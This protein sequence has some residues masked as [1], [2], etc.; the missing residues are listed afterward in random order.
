[1]TLRGLCVTFLE[2]L[3]LV[4]AL[5]TE[6]REFFVVA[7]CVGGVIVYSLFSL[8]LASVTLRAESRLNTKTA[9]RGDEV[10]Y[11]LRLRG[12]A[13]LPVTGYL[14]VKSTEVFNKELRRRKH[15]FVML[16]SFKASHDFDFEMPCLHVGLWEVGIRKLRFEDV[17]GLFSLPL[18]RTRRYDY[19]IDLTIMPKIHP[20]ERETENSSSGDY[21]STSVLDAEEGELLGDSRIYRE[22][23]T[24]KRINWKMSARTK[25][26]YSRQYEMPQKP[27]IV[28]VTDSAISSVSINDVTDISG[29]V[30]VSLA[31]YFLMQNNVVD[32]VVARDSQDNE[33]KIHHLMSDKDVSRMQ[34][35]FANIIF[36]KNTE[37]LYS[38]QLDDTQCFNADKL[39]IITS[40]PSAEL[41][42]DI[43]DFDKSGKLARCI[44]PNIPKVTD[45]IPE[46]SR[47]D[48]ECVIEITSADHIIEKVGAA[49]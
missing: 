42:S 16:P 35:N 23:D 31:N 48:E 28:I 25:T 19:R 30:A 5:G 26:L 27:K 32:I 49:L 7:L 41:V 45:G 29:E 15:S 34:H 33:N 46:K 3:L 12:I 20:L 10:K 47:Y 11:T 18:M 17:F 9:Y 2:L 36:Y 39:Y 14:S 8:L 37:E 40:N 22:G 21:G 13:I 24:L 38:S 1:M 43:S 4:L 6:I 44:I